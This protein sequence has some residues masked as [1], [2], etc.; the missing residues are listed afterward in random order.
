MLKEIIKKGRNLDPRPPIRAFIFEV[1]HPKNSTEW[2]FV[3]PYG[4]GDTYITCGFVEA[5]LKVHGGSS[6]TVYVQEDHAFIARLFPAVSTIK[7]I[8]RENAH[9]FIQ[10]NFNRDRINYAHF[11]APE[12][13]DLIGYKGITL[14][15]CYRSLFKLPQST[16][17]AEPRKPTSSEMAEVASF[18]RRHN[19]PFKK[20]VIVAPEARS[21]PSL[22]E[23]ILSELCTQLQKRGLTPFINRKKAEHPEKNTSVD[24]IPPELIRAA[25]ESAGWVITVRSGLAD[26]LSDL[27]CKLTVL[28]PDITWHGGAFI[29]GTSLKLMG[30]SKEAQ[31]YVIDEKDPDFINK[32]IH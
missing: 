27:N 32:I 29:K 12:A 22:S 25:A 9:S 11:S 13:I 16:Q 18:F 2:A 19:L 31:E 15:D 6:C 1:L 24:F 10:H 23:K 20:T 8:S 14:I 3:C 21:G 26:V 17:L 28:Y 30:L 5:I 4:L 7:T